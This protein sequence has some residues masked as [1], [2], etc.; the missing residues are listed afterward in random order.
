MKPLKLVMNAFGPYA[1]KI[2]VEFEQFG[3]GGLFLITGDTGAG[4]TTIF[5]A[6]TFALFNKTSGTD[7]EVNT[8]R[9]DYA[10]ESEDT[11]V[12]LTFSH[13]GR[14]YQIFRS[15]QYERLKKNGTG[16]TRQPA[17][18]EFR[19][20]PDTPIEGTKQVDEAVEQLL[21]IN[22]EQFKQI[23]MIAQGEFREVLNADSKKRGE[24]LQKI[25]STEGY[26]KM[27]FLM[28]ERYKKAYGEMADLFRSIDQYFDGVRYDEN[29]AYAEEIEEEKKKGNSEHTQYQI[30][31]KIELLETMIQEDHQKLELLEADAKKKKEDADEKVKTYTLIHST[32][33]LFE[34]YDIA[35]EEKKKLE[36]RKEEMRKNTEVLEKQ[37]KAVYD[38][39]PEYDAYTN[40]KKNYDEAVCKCA[41]E[42]K[43]YQESLI[44]YNTAV[45]C[46]D[47]AAGKKD[48][49][50]EKKQEALLLKKDEEKYIK[51]DELDKRIL[52]CRTEQNKILKQKSSQEEK[53]GQLTRKIAEEKDRLENLADASEKCVIAEA[54]YHKLNEKCKRL[55][56][57]FVEKLPALNKLE[58]QL[59]KVQKSYNEK[60]KL[61]DDIDCQY[62]QY[63]KLLEE[64]R[65]GILASG[66]TDGSPCPVC[67]STKH[68]A[69]AQLSKESVTEEEMKKL[70]EKLQKAENE[71]DSIS[72]KAIETNAKF[73]TEQRNICAEIL[74]ELKLAE[75]NKNSDKEILLLQLEQSWEEIKQQKL[76]TKKEWD[77]LKQEKQ[78]WIE[79][80]KLQEEDSN[81]LEHLKKCLE[82]TKEVLQEYETQLANLDGQLKE[83]SELKYETL[84]EAKEIRKKLEQQAE[85]IRLEIEKQQT[86]VNQVKELVTANEARVK[87][88]KE[89]ENSLKNSM[90][91][92]QKIYMKAIEC[93]G[94]INEEDFKKYLVSKDSICALEG[95]I[96]EY[97]EAVTANEANVTSAQKNI[98]GKERMDETKAEAEKEESVKAEKDVQNQ[99]TNLRNRKESN[100]G[101]LEKIKKQ[102]NKATKKLEDVSRLYNLKNLLKGNTTGKNRTSFETY[103]QMSGF[104]GIIYAANKRLLPISGGQ[105]QLYRH[106]D[107]GAKGNIALRLDILDNY[108]GKKRPVSTLSGGESFMASLSLALGLSDRVTANAGGIKIDTLFIDEGFG[109]LDEKS[110]NDAIGMLQ[111]LSTG[112]KLIGIISH[113]QELKEEISKKILIHKSNKGSSIEI[114]LGL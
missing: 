89:S 37:K 105:Y 74:Q 103:V 111:E 2:E 102:N 68:P 78:E 91:E 30:N 112:N 13:M 47:K 98:A 42:K 43:K 27:G 22:Y 40:E 38:V 100:E 85:D 17:K 88:C 8:L 62:K 44:R 39:K 25:F 51:R 16:V 104:D 24:I 64:S 113:R 32:N 52:E 77:K 114:D 9:S 56:S 1:S 6:I 60:R 34:K 7:R 33:E 81:Q 90:D 108:T 106:E 46:L 110:L 19:R 45:E 11:F 23:S 67:G 31:R 107:P 69:P 70:K 48:I 3:E 15:P 75:E 93:Q 76:D 57:I 5:D 66:L 65:A 109:T 26:K 73:E 87:S 49:A 86:N 82:G 58:K 63:E 35:L 72:K 92:K 18:A 14:I 55:E 20:E 28:E 101:V 36:L 61:Y 53:I 50:E 95:L 80:G 41:E 71:K 99:L 84:A 29:S 54:E 96:R 4:K 21:K 59:V 12:E 10:K 94:F 83:M 97:K 79:L